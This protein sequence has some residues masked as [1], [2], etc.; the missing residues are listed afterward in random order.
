MAVRKINTDYRENHWWE[1]CPIHERELVSTVISKP[2][3]CW[4]CHR[5]ELK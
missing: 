3:V 1:F 4:A 5:K 2:R